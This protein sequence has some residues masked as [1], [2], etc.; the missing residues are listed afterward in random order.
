[1][2]IVLE[3]CITEIQH[4]VVRLWEKGL[5]AKDIHTEMFPVYVGDVV[6]A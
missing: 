5:P 4:S 1:M 6:V 2:A 3:E